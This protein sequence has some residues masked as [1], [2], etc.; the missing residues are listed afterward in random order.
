[1]NMKFTIFTRSWKGEAEL[2]KVVWVYALP[3]LIVLALLI[4]ALQM[5]SMKQPS[6]GLGY[7]AIPLGILRLGF[8]IWLCASLWRCAL[9]VQYKIWSYVARTFSVLL[10]IGILLPSVQQLKMWLI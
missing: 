8:N 10:A 3:L 7:L 6:L 2:Y 4:E 1:M 9:N 5:A